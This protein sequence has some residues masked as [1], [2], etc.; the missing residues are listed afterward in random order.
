[1]APQR[2]ID[3]AAFNQSLTPYGRWVETPEYGRV[4]VPNDTTRTDWQPYTD[5]RWVWTVAGWSYV[6]T[7][8][9]GW[10]AYHY[11]RWG[12]RGGLG[13]YWVPAYTW[14][15]AWV[16]WRRV[17]VHYAWAPYAPRG[18]IYPRRWPGWVVVPREQFRRPIATVRIARPQAHAILRSAQRPIGHPGHFSGVQVQQHRSNVRHDGVGHGGAGHR[19]RR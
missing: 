6:S 18:Y 9:W 7:V 15:P 8:P 13:W 17:G 14:G 10:A 2:P 4:W 16:S 1:V 11:G 3:Q 12:W 5:G 19:H